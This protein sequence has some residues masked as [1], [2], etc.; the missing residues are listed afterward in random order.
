MFIF[1]ALFLSAVN[2]DGRTALHVAAAEGHIEVVEFLVKTGSPLFVRDRWG[3]SPLQEAIHHNQVKIAT[4]LER[5][6]TLQHKKHLDKEYRVFV[7]LFFCFHK[8][9]D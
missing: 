5:V 1:F 7:F 9:N 2:Y 6:E 8:T 4:L 3:H